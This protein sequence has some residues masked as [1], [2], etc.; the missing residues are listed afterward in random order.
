[1]ILF[2]IYL[3]KPITSYVQSLHI[4]SKFMFT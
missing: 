1:M 2:L 3:S 4:F